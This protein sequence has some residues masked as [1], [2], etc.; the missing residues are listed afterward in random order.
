MKK[1]I[2]AVTTSLF[3]F[4]ALAQTQQELVVHLTSGEQVHFNLE[5]L[6][7]TTFSGDSIVITTT[8]SRT[9]YILTDVQ[10][11]T[12]ESFSQ[13]LNDL[14]ASDI[15]IRENNG[16]L[17]IEGLAEKTVVEVY[18][19]EGKIVTRTQAHASQVTVLPLS[20]CPA[21]TYI[22]HTGGISY[23]FTRQ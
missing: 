3:A 1:F 16:Q 17:E 6:P 18:S 5:T 20:T 9:S 19:M 10:F 23:K 13:G 7:E 11:F 14:R 22:I 8:E 4:G 21:G 15:R 2:F 12:Y